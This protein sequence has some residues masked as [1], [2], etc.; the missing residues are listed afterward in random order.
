VAASGTN[1]KKKNASDERK[2]MLLNIDPTVMKTGVTVR[3]KS[4]LPLKLT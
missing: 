4:K 1:R 2:Q 3:A